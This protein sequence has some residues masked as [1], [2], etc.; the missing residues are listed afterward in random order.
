MM[1]SELRPLQRLGSGESR[2]GRYGGSVDPW[3]R[4]TG[5]DV[6]VCI[7]TD[8][9]PLLSGCQNSTVEFHHS[10]TPRWHR[11]SGEEPTAKPQ[12]LTMAHCVNHTAAKCPQ[13]VGV[14]RNAAMSA[15]VC[16]AM[17]GT[18]GKVRPMARGEWGATL[19]QQQ[20]PQ[21]PPGSGTLRLQDPW[22]KNIVMLGADR[23]PLSSIIWL[24]PD[25][26]ADDNEVCLDQ[27]TT[28]HVVLRRTVE[29][30]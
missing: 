15:G 22:K 5:L 21:T 26:A 16:N 2:Q 25:H 9:T 24:Q 18:S 17:G 3:A 29:S 20:I 12:L 14:T 6:L 11:P 27:W 23:P 7:A 10:I 19:R 28:H 4:P 30:L 1:T 8:R 13:M